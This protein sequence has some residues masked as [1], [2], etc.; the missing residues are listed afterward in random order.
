MQNLPILHH[1]TAYI[2]S[3]VASFVTRYNQTH[4]NQVCKFRLF[5][6][7]LA[8]KTS[9]ALLLCLSNM[10]NCKRQVL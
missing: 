2:F 8:S 1:S 6:V 3:G 4:S 10:V 7:F 5:D 9:D